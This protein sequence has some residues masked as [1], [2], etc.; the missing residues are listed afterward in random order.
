MNADFSLSKI[1]KQ[2]YRPAAEVEDTLD[3]LRRNLIVGEKFRVGR[4]AIAR[5]LSEE[6][7][8]APLPKGTEMGTSIEGQTLFGDDTSIWACL[9]AE[10]SPLLTTVEQFKAYVEA[11]WTRGAKLLQQDLD[12][13]D[14]RHAKFITNLAAMAKH[15]TDTALPYA[16]ENFRVPQVTGAITVKVGEISTN[17]KNDQA[18]SYILNAPGVSPHISVLGKTRSG[19]TRTGIVIAEHIAAQRPLPMLMIDP[20]GE[21][22]SK[23]KFVKK[24]E[25]Q[26]RTL[27][28]RFP[29]IKPLDVPNQSIPLDFLYRSPRPTPV[30]LAQLAMSF[31]DSFQKCL[32]AK[33]DAALN[34]LRQAVQ[35]LLT[36]TTHPIS[37]ESVLHEVQDANQ[38]QGRASNTIEAKLSEM[39]ALRLFEPKIPPHEFFADRWAI[40][41]GDATEESKRLV[42]F[43]LLDALAKY[44]LSL[45]DSDTDASG[46]RAVRHLLLIDEAKEILSYKH[47][48]LS[49]LVRKSAAKGGIVMLLS[50]SPDDF[51]GEEDDFLSQI[52]SIV[53]FTSSTNSVKDLRAALGRRLAPEDFSDKNLPTGVALTKLP[54]QDLMKVRAWQ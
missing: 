38:R 9:I 16:D 47:N 54:K 28:D 3:E 25:W 26:G 35:D 34:T 45:P 42:I 51:E 39:C 5:S 22:I 17:I 52:S 12:N 31:K 13:A 7:A 44:L 43:L 10:A 24:T 37:L 23:G 11:H 49:N 36:D 40:G 41:L 14:Q 50:Q 29:G 2:R 46:H 21:F 19:K 15:R 32:R 20:K 30:E 27:A 6:D 1:D 33:G 53:V 48:A 4:L 18:V 8:I